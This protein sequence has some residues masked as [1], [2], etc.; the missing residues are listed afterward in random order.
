MLSEDNVARMM[1]L[2]N[3]LL[4][5]ISMGF[6]SQGHQLDFKLVIPDHCRYLLDINNG[7]D[8]PMTYHTEQI[9]F[10]VYRDHVA[11]MPSHYHMTMSEEQFFIS[12]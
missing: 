6:S 8:I 7:S 2:L 1:W 10:L 11:Y 4:D 12:L 5:L 3:L 9:I